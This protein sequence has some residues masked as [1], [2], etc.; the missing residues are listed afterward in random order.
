MKRKA[1]RGR[2]EGS[3]HPYVT[4][5]E[6][7]RFA[8]SEGRVQ[9]HL[10]A[11]P[12]EQ[13]SAE[14]ERRSNSPLCNSLYVSGITRI[15]SNKGVCHVFGIRDTPPKS[16]SRSAVRLI[17]RSRLLQKATGSSC[18]YKDY[19]KYGSVCQ[20]VSVDGSATLVSRPSQGRSFALSGSAGSVGTSL[21]A[22]FA[23]SFIQ[24]SRLF[25]PL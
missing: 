8:I 20:S 2:S 19:S 6:S 17:P 15:I 22:S 21:S 12:S 23:I 10:G 18:R 9:A 1:L 25:A 3:I 4:E 16:F 13:T 24:S 5:A 7:R 11:I 14:Q